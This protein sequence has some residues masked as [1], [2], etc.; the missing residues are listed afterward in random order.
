MALLF[1][2]VCSIKKMVGGKKWGG[3]GMVILSN[4]IRHISSPP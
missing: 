2:K 3:H 4:A 1:V